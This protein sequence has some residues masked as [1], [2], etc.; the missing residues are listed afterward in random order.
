MESDWV[1]EVN[2]LQREFK[3]PLVSN[4]KMVGPL[5]SSWVS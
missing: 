4:W 2:D 1:R 5:D 3:V